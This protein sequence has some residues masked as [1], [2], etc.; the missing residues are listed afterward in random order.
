MVLTNK[1][2]GL[3]GLVSI[4]GCL[5]EVSL[6]HSRTRTEIERSYEETCHSGSSDRI[7]DFQIPRYNREIATISE[8]TYVFS[9]PVWHTI[10]ETRQY[11]Y[12][13]TSPMPALGRGYNISPIDARRIL[14]DGRIEKLDVDGGL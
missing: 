1:Q 13:C 2:L 12:G 4:V 6:V 14:P 5:A 10:L 7:L 3:L 11:D 8:I 9:V